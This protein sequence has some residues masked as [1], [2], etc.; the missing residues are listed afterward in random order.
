MTTWDEILEAVS[1]SLAGDRDRGRRLLLRCWHNTDEGNPAQR[2]V[3]A[4]YLADLEPDLDDEVAWDERALAAF[5][6]VGPDD[7]APIGLPDPRVF[8][9]SLHLNLGDGYL[10]QGNTDA[11]RRHLDEGIA[12]AQV[13]AP[14]GPSALIRRGLDGLQRRLDAISSLSTVV[15]SDVA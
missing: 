4:H 11:A 3:L 7:L 1:A 10:R 15:A 2:C 6:K 9:P 8:S 13:L 12:D 5:V 14:E